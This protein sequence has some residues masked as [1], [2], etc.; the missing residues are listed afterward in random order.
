MSVPPCLK[1]YVNAKLL[2]AAVTVQHMQPR[3]VPRHAESDEDE[4]ESDG[5]GNASTEDDDSTYYDYSNY[6]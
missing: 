2:P 3:G 6:Y 5:Y 4:E 1:P